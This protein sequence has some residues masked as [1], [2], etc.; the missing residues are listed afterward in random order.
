[1][2]RIT[3]KRMKQIIEK[4]KSNQINDHIENFKIQCNID[5]WSIRKKYRIILYNKK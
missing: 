4:K 2:N 1:M 3:V 5:T